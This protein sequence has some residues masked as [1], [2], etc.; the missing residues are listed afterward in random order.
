MKDIGTIE[1]YGRLRIRDPNTDKIFIDRRTDQ[2]LKEVN[3]ER[4]NEPKH[5]RLPKNNK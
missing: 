1:I 5:R 4:N 3:N 2:P